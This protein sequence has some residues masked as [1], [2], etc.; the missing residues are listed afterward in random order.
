MIVGQTVTLVLSVTV[1]HFPPGT[2]SLQDTVIPS[3]QRQSVP[4]P[5]TT[6]ADSVVTVATFPFEVPSGPLAPGTRIRFTRDSIQWMSAITVS[7]VLGHVPGV[8]IAR[9]GFLGQPEY[10]LYAGR[11]PVAIEMFWDGIPLYPMGGDSVYV[12]PGRIPLSYLAAIDVEVLPSSLRVYLVTN[13]YDRVGSRSSLRVMSGAFSTAEYAGLFQKRWANG[14]GLS[15]AADFTGSEGAPAV[16]RSD[17]LLDLW[18]HGEWQASE[19]TGVGYQI[20]R[21]DL[22]RDDPVEEQGAPTR[23]GVRTDVAFR[24]HHATSKGRNGLSFDLG[25]GSSAWTDDSI[26]GDQHH[27]YASGTIRLQLPYLLAEVTGRAGDYRVRRAVEAR[28][29]FMP[30]TPLVLSASGMIND[31]GSGRETRTGV[32]S[33]ALILGPLSI[34]GQAGHRDG[35]QAPALSNDS[36][37]Q[38]EDFSVSI[39]MHTRRITGRVGVAKRDAFVPLPTPDYSFLATWEETPAANFVIADVQLRPIDPVTISA[40]YSHPDVT[41]GAL[42]PPKHGRA[43]L[44]FRSRFLRQFRS[45]VYDFK[46]SYGIEFWSRGVAGISNGAPVELPGATF[47]ELFAQIQ[48]VDF[49]VFYNLRNARNSRAQYVPGLPYP[50][51]AQ[52]FGVKWEFVN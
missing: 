47:H 26:V 43:D 25:V 45:G 32:V 15:L 4:Q 31:Y 51:N 46:I 28:F 35:V 2:V 27:R 44:V 6:A 34:T 11:G 50:R 10:A 7:D 13:R 21:Q 22:Q 42:Q 39:G 41:G 52:T 9:G 37:Q 49:K 12:D 18:L 16:S 1:A 17:N 19:A 23:N 30:I 33:G 24:M 5:D 20:R 8:F 38:T 14:L 40:W 29:G 48:L 36:T 3:P